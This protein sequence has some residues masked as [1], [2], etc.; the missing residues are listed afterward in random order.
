[1]LNQVADNAEEEKLRSKIVHVRYKQII[2][3][4]ENRK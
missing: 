3:S 4:L 2:R 1:M